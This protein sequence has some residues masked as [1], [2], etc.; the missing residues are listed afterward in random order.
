MVMSRPYHTPGDDPNYL[1]GIVLLS[2]CVHH[3]MMSAALNP[4]RGHGV[5]PL[6]GTGFRRHRNV[7]A[8]NRLGHRIQPEARVQL[9]LAHLICDIKRY[10][11]LEI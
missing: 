10:K 7:R 2:F 6:G 11:I 8:E 9:R 1:V 3:I 4:S 5:V